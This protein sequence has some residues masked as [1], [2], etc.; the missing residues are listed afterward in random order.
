M[1]LGELLNLSRELK[2]LSLR[3]LEKKS[4]VSNA[5]ISQIETGKVP[6][7]GFR[8]ICKIAD[9]LGVSLKRLGETVE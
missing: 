7:P 5:L 4:G 8:T 6:N 3:E 2:G 1:T 9:V